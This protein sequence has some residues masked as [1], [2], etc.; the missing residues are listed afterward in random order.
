MFFER[1][2]SL[3]VKPSMREPIEV[4]FV[5]AKMLD[6]VHAV[7]V[8]ERGIALRMNVRLDAKLIGTEVDLVISLPGLPSFHTRGAI[9]RFS[10][11]DGYVVGIK[12]VGLTAKGLEAIRSFIEHRADA[13]SSAR[14]RLSG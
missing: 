14:I 12:F 9:R 3:R 5:A 7:D 11:T 13:R 2:D 4:Q 8:S 6:L 10:P 1:R